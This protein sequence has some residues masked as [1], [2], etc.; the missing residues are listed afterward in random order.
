MLRYYLAALLLAMAGGQL[1]SLPEFAGIIESY[2]LGPSGFA[3]PL[4]L[5]IVGA[6]LA[7][8]AGLLGPRSWQVPG[9]TIT[10]AV[11]IAWTVLAVQAFVRGLEVTNCG[12]FGAYFGQELRW[13]VLLQDALFVASAGWLRIRIARASPPAAANVTATRHAPTGNP[14]G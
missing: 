6:E 14:T 11:A 1:L 8:G 13:Y 7:G 9:S 4:A 3:W 2:E 12:C 5:A 10:L